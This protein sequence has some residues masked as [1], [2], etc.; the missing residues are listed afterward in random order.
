MFGPK[1]FQFH[2]FNI[3]SQRNFYRSNEFNSNQK[4]GART[5]S[6]GF[7]INNIQ[8]NN[9]R[10]KNVMPTNF[11]QEIPSKNNMNILSKLSQDKYPSQK[12]INMD[13]ESILKYGESS[14]I[15]EL[16]PHMIYNDLSFAK[17]N[18]LKLVLSKF[19]TLLKFIFSQQ[20][21]LLNNNNKIEA[22]FNN[23]N[24]NMNKKIRQLE[25]DEYK[26]DNLI[27][28][29]KKQIL[30]LNEKIK[31]YKNILKNSGKE[32]LIPKTYYSNLNIKNGLYECHICL[33]KKFKNHE[34]M[35][36]HYIKE[37]YISKN[38]NLNMNNNNNNTYNNITKSY[39]DNKLF[40]LKNEV[41]N[42]ILNAYQEKNNENN[43]NINNNMKLM[44]QTNN[45][46]KM[47]NFNL[48]PND[49]EN[50]NINNCLTKIEYE[51]KV[52][53]DLL[54]QKINDMKDEVFS[55]LKNLENQQQVI[56][57]NKLKEI[58]QLKK[59]YIK[60]NNINSQINNENHFENMNIINNQKIE[61][62]NDI[63]NNEKL[64]LGNSSNDKENH[65]INININNNKINNEN[66]AQINLNQNIIKE[67]K[68]PEKNDLNNMILKSS[69]NQNEQKEIGINKN[70]DN[71]TT[72][73]EISQNEN[74]KLVHST[75]KYIDKSKIIEEESGRRDST[76]NNITQ[77][78]NTNTPNATLDNKD[79]MYTNTGDSVNENPLS[80]I[81]QAINEAKVSN[82]QNQ[83]DKDNFINK[84]K[85]RDD[86][87]LLNKDKNILDIENNY[88]VIKLK[89]ISEFGGGEDNLIKE[90]QDK[91]FNEDNQNLEK[92]DYE[93][94][95]RNIIKDNNEKFGHDKKYREFYNNLIKKNELS[96]LL[97]KEMKISNIEINQTR[98]DID[99]TDIV[100]KS[101]LFESKDISVNKFS[102]NLEFLNPSTNKI[103]NSEFI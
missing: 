91:Y 52:Q 11:S 83:I 75:G 95:I 89:N 19:Q 22:M 68:E 60:N 98:L 77:N 59:H 25:S 43:N 62:E 103:R 69:E 16:L 102:K 29:N 55:E 7:N 96:D 67:V 5:Y 34:E 26:M 49:E 32:Q 40:V 39:L 50:I 21:N 100:K 54:N 2:K 99:K 81:S 65:E 74:T 90:H 97:S 28:S 8:I 45:K 18:H 44:S 64:E 37:H 35:Q 33:G 78:N 30:K 66:Q 86:N 56:N 17:N 46:I 14:K 6:N 42:I 63:K 94:I 57:D 12:V 87:L 10:Y 20:Q 82:V 58:E 36:E 24:S 31:T 70:I 3:N 23:K 61:E 13:F 80:K 9:N 38:N 1:N 73:K 88:D 47:S 27:N 41:K 48:L 92:D 15:D 53:Y 4:S 51:Q 84:I 79:K 72:N 93:N 71:N 85:E 101:S 76:V